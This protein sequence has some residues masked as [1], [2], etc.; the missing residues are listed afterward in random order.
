MFPGVD[1]NIEYAQLDPGDTLYAY[2]DG[3]TEARNPEGDFLTDDGLLQTIAGTA[4]PRPPSCWIGS[5]A[6]C[7]NSLPMLTSS[8]ISP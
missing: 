6:N 1:F 7:R 4:A 5:R 3:V 2:T 8:M